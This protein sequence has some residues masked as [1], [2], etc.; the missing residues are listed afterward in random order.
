MLLDARKTARK[1]T[2]RQY[3]LLILGTIAIGAFL[4]FFLLTQNSLWLD[5]G[6]SLDYSDGSTVREVIAK[7]INSDA[8]DR[9]QPLYY[10][11]L[12]YWRGIFGSSE[13]AV[14]SL[15]AILG[16][17]TVI[18]LSTTAWQLYGKKHALWTT[19]FLSL[20]S[21]GVYYSQQTRAYT[22]LL[23]LAALQ[24]YFF[25]QILQHKSSRSQTISQILFCLTTVI[26][27][28][29]SIF[30]GIYTLALCIAHLLVDKNVKRWFRWWL[31]VAIS[32]LPAVFFYLASPVATDPSRVHVTPARQ[33]I[34]QNTLFVLYGLLVGETY[35]PP[36][37]QLRDGDRVQII[38]SYLPLLLLLLA[39]VGIVFIGLIVG[40]KQ[41]SPEA[42]KYRSIDKFFLYTFAT[43]FV[44]A[45]VFAI[46][47]RYNWLPR[48]SFYIY[49]P[50]AFL[51][52]IALRRSGD[53]RSLQWN[54][55]YH[56]AFVALL[57]LNLYSTYNYYFE[58][59]YQRENYREI[60]Q[61]LKA[62]NSEN[63]KSVILYGA[64]N[65]LPY[66]GDS[67]TIHGLGLDT[68]QLAAE[69]SR[70]TNNSPKVLIA[71]EYQDFWE[72]KRNFDLESSM[73]KS[74]NLE[75]HVRFINFDVYHYVRR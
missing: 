8:G 66:Y 62:N 71:I 4:R 43:S 32:C 51:L 18:I 20:S 34:V 47:T 63:A 69:V 1:N 19:L 15:S 35:G 27:L 74:Y 52:P 64:P 25:S 10:V 33:P 6:A 75:S 17:G 22:L 26:G 40:W 68:T 16:V 67:V 11:V 28:F 37:E 21:Y 58:P 42:R 9:F 13:F 3:Y 56:F 44:V 31:P 30:I 61:Y 73:A 65:L 12:Y 23:F 59:R 50:M 60:A 72:Q 45:V 39:V 7:I 36:I 49:I 14:R 70:V 57:L 55:I 29:C 5:E 53:R 2:D 41:H 48:H 38:L 54:R 46:V 24:L